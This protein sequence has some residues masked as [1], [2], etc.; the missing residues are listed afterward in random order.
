MSS[1]S[2][3][4]EVDVVE[5]AVVMRVSLGLVDARSITRNTYCGYSGW[6]LGATEYGLVRVGSACQPGLRSSV[7][8]E[9]ARPRQLRA[10]GYRVRCASAR[11]RRATFVPLAR[12]CAVLAS[13]LGVPA[14]CHWLQRA[15][16]ERVGS[17]GQLRAT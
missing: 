2:T 17:A 6:Q 15:R 14:S 8:C 4:A 13:R 5:T 9:L 16:C 3:L 10:T 12:A 11:A 7:C 1:V